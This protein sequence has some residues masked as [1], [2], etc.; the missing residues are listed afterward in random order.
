MFV[1]H[2]CDGGSNGC[3]EG[4]GESECSQHTLPCQEKIWMIMKI[5]SIYA[6]YYQILGGDKVFEVRNPLCKTREENSYV[7]VCMEVI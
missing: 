4:G 7:H 2:T 1:T 3:W 6:I 5:I